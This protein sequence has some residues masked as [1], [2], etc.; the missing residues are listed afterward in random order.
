LKEQW[1]EVEVDMEKRL[2][3]KSEHIRGLVSKPPTI[4]EK[5]EGEVSGTVA[6]RLARWASQIP[7]S[8]NSAIPPSPK[9]PSLPPS[10]PPKTKKQ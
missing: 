4:L 5:E 1:K 8:E 7:P 9:E 3:A 2:K 6:V 10:P